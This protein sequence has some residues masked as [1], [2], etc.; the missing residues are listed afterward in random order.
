[1]TTEAAASPSLQDSVASTVFDL[2]AT[3]SA[4]YS[5]SGTSWANLVA[6]P[7]DGASQSAYNFTISGATFTGSAGSA[8]AYFSLDGN[9]SFSITSGNTTFINNL[10]KTT[11]GQ[12]FWLLFAFY[13]PDDATTDWLFADYS[14]SPGIR[15]FINTTQ[16][17]GFRQHGS[18]SSQVNASATVAEATPVMAIISHSHSTNETKFWISATTG[19]A[20]AHTFSSTTS[21]AQSA[22]AVAY[23]YSAYMQNG[24]RVYTI[25]GGNEYL[26][27]TKAGALFSALETRHSRDYTP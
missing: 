23:N 24:A 9:D 27:N 1:V 21:N 3:I 6:S 13:L 22:F 16:T 4:S 11:G 26:D 19:E 18:T 14:T 20:V 5:G 17:L 10:H 8:S 12:D 2:D 25:A 7:A 15:S